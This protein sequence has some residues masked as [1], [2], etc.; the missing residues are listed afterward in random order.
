MALVFSDETG[1]FVMILYFSGCGYKP[2]DAFKEVSLM[3]SFFRSRSKPEKR[4]V[5]IH[6]QRKRKRKEN[7]N[8]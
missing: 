7:E 1:Y 5:K 3:L 2:E 8:Q 6:G 4:F